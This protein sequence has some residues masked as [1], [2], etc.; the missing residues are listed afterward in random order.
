[1]L[2]FNFSPFPELETNRLRLRRL[3]N[4]D[5]NE[6]FA[7][8]SDPEAM[9]FIPRPLAKNLDDALAHI[10]LINETIDKN[11][12]INWA[13]T[14]KGDDKVIGIMGYYRA[15]PEHFRAEIGYMI[16]PGFNGRGITTEAIAKLIEYGFR[17][18][19]LHSIEAVIDPDNIGSARV[20]EKNKFTKEAHL[21]QNEFYE[22]KFLDTVI[23]SRLKTD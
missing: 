8:R 19:K 20:L 9:K 3:T 2:T 13:V 11:E 17:A 22:G 6:V 23:Y 7:M 4:N 21:R 18:M 12:G 16:S 5:A 15:K 10:A 1:M 14:L